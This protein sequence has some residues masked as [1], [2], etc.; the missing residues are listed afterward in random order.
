VLL[1]LGGWRGRSGAG[2]AGFA[3]IAL[4][5]LSLAPAA[6]AVTE[7]TCA[8]LEEELTEAHAG[9][10]LRLP[11]GTCETNVK[12]TNDE[13]FT[14]EG[15]PSG[16]TLKAKEGAKAILEATGSG[17]VSFTLSS[18]TFTGTTSHDAVVIADQNEAVTLSNDT[19]TS[20]HG[21]TG[22]ALS[23]GNGTAGSASNPTRLVNDTFG[24]AGAGNSAFAG[25]AVFVVTSNPLEIE[26]STF[27]AN[28]VPAAEPGGALFIDDALGGNA[29]V[30]LVG[31]TFGG[32][33]ETE[34]N[35]AGS[36]GGGAFIQLSHAQTLT[37]IANTFVGN[38]IVGN[39][40]SHPRVG[41]GLAVEL[42]GLADSGFAV[43]QRENFFLGNVI[44]ATDEST[45]HP[46]PAGGAGEWVFG[47]TV[48]STADLY[49]GNAILVNDGLPTYPPEGGGLGVLGEKAEGVIPAQ[50]GTFVGAND[51]FM[52]NG[53]AAGGWGGAIYSGFTAPYCSSGCPGSSIT[54]R[55]S[56][57]VSNE[58]GPS[59][60]SEGGAVWG[61][62]SDTLAVQNSII[63][64]N[65]APQV[66]GFGGGASFVFSD[67]C[68][69]LGGT[70]ISGAGLICAN[71]HL[72]EEGEETSAS[73]TVDAGSN[74]LV[75]EGL[76]TDAVGAARITAG[77]CG[78][79]ATVDMGAFELPAATHCPPP[80]HTT[81]TTTTTTSTSASGPGT[82]SVSSARANSTGTEVTLACAGGAHQV[83]E[84]GATMY[85]TEQRVG[86]K[87]ASL[88]RSSGK[89]KHARRVTVVVGSTQYKLTGGQ[90]TKLK[91]PL[92][93]GGKLLLRRF[94]RVPVRL[95][96]KAK[97]NG[98]STVVS[99]RRFTIAQTRRHKHKRA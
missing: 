9:D 55:D 36:A 23:I 78:D 98:T 69:E 87:V 88:S 65:S 43:N 86:Q 97:A 6:H 74:A 15:S 7:V 33:L 49:A 41:A 11:A 47:N 2:V 1:R 42:R 35:K 57:V 63:A 76:T 24:T 68:N 27:A 79:A 64:N 53:V 82:A 22:G 16:T 99:T 46:Q 89:R 38:A 95:V 75:P 58:V 21:T 51:V 13:A 28:S 20:N 4:A 50:P 44:A 62:G 25:G 5:A 29:A 72:G 52:E 39:K 85:T 67:V 10:V 45:E 56:T 59:S 26:N 18:L 19:F 94:H 54:L 71:P 8:H 30:K 66:F 3:A 17:G 93:S 70:S 40:A 83:C 73:P 91:V 80:A 77:R 34:A 90:T 32:L 60:E 81:T 48:Q 37:L 31:N 14:L 61:A 84:G 96:V 92:N 12:T